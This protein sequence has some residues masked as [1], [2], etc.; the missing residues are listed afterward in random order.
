MNI[1]YLMVS[2]KSILGSRVLENRTEFRFIV[3]ELLGNSRSLNVS[4]AM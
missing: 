1:K 2:S 4:D 3:S